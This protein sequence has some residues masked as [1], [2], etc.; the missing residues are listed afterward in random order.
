MSKEESKTWG[1]KCIHPVFQTVQRRDKDILP[2]VVLK[3]WWSSGLKV[4]CHQDGETLAD[5]NCR[6][7]NIES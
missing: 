1:V 2:G 6:H 5:H 7:Q 4:N 3:M